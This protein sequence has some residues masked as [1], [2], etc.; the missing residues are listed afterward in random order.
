MYSKIRHS[1]E[2]GDKVSAISGHIDTYKMPA[3][4]WCHDKTKSKARFKLMQSFQVNCNVKNKTKPT[5]K[6]K[7]V[8]IEYIFYCILPSRHRTSNS[9]LV[10][11]FITVVLSI[12]NNPFRERCTN[13]NTLTCR[14]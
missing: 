4:L 7:T 2:S 3:P 14:V 9:D 10:T 1:D 6:Q 12:M 5:N 13:K 11:W 8:R